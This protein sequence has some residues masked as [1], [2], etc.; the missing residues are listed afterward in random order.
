MLKTPISA[1]A[2][3]LVAAIV[4]ALVSSLL[5]AYHY[6]ARHNLLEGARREVEQLASVAAVQVNGDLHRKLTTPEQAGSEPHL[7]A[8]APLVAF[9]KSSR[10]L[11]FVYTAI[12]DKNQIRFVLSTN[13]L[14]RAPGDELPADTMMQL[15]TGVDPQLTQALTQ[16]ILISNP[17]LVQ[18]PTHAL[19]SGYAPFFDSQKKL[20]GVVGVDMLATTLEQR[21]RHLALMAGALMLLNALVS[22]ALGGLYTRMQNRA[23]AQL[24]LAAQLQ[25][26]RDASTYA[27]NVVA[28]AGVVAHEFSQH[29]TAASGFVDLALSNRQL[30][31]TSTLK[32]EICSAAAALERSGES[33]SQLRT[34]AGGSFCT[35]ESV[36]LTSLL[37]ISI[38][39]LQ[40]RGLNAERLQL[41]A[42]CE[43]SLR[44]L[45]DRRQAI[46]AIVH[47]L[48]NALEADFSANVSLSLVSVEP[49]NQSWKINW[50]RLINASGERAL[51]GMIVENQGELSEAV[52]KHLDE[53]F[54]TSKGAGRGLGFAVVKGTLKAMGGA[55][56]LQSQ[57]GKT[58]FALLFLK[59]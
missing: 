44:V 14:Y 48:R 59:S 49:T 1:R 17:A 29:L 37:D 27:G 16:G 58:R 11:V 47:I 32:S 42:S 23:V 12:L 35:L 56:Q 53:P 8:L 31:A 33:I 57:H 39:Q 52:S 10:D 28:L 21:Q 22:I 9:H 55:L 34:L 46:T 20:V 13:F 25:H 3:A 26:E 19:L 15:Y 24:K 18:E 51:A 45:V 6:A 54:Y 40:S 36:S 5:L 50:Q 43:S 4:F 7:T 2:G 38:Q 30:D 41:D